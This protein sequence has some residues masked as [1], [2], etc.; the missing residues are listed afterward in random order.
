M[1]RKKKERK[2]AQ[3]KK[4]NN[5]RKICAAAAYANARPMKLD[6]ILAVVASQLSADLSQS[7]YS[8]CVLPLHFSSKFST[9]YWTNIS[10]GGMFQ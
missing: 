6:P 2:N 1:K 10:I 3:M 8:I 9:A 7:E 5:S 4:T